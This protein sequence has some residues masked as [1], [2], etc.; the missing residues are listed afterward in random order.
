MQVQIRH[1]IPVTVCLLALILFIIPVTAGTTSVHIIKYA[2][3]GVTILD[4]QTVDF[5]WLETNLQVYGDGTTHY[6]HQGPVFNASITDKWNPEENDPAILTKD[7]GAVK[8]TDL[9]D[10]CDLVGGM[11]P[12]DNNVTLKASDGFSKVFAYSSVYTPE[13]RTGPIVLCW[14]RADLGYVNESF[15]TGIRNVM[16]ADTSVNPWGDHV[17]GL[18]DMHEAYPEE[19]WYYYQPGQPSTTGLSVQ[20]IDRVLIYSNEPAPVTLFDGMVTLTAGTTFSVVPYQNLT[21]DYMVDSTTPLGALNAASIAGSGFSYSVSDKSFAAKGILLL[22]EIG[23]Y[24]Y[25]KTTNMA[26]IC[27]VNGVT[28]DDYGSPSTDGFNIKELQDGDQVD[29]YFGVKPV[30]PESA[31]GV[32]KIL[33]DII[34]PGPVVDTLFNGTV[35]LTPGSTFSVVPYQNL[36]ADYTVDSTTPL[37]ALN[38]ASI[39]GSG[40]SYS[41]S[42][43]SYATKG[44]LLLDETGGYWYNK[45]TNMAWICQLNGVTLDDYGSPATDGFNIREVYDG[46]QVDYYFGLKPVTPEN[47]TAVA[48]ILVRTG[49]PPGDWNLAMN[50]RINRTISRQEFDDAL[51]CV[52]SG[53]NVTW[54]DEYGNVWGGIPLWVLVGMVDDAEG[55]AHWTFND[56]LAAEGYTV[57]VR[58]DDWD[59]SLASTDIAR[60]DGYIVANTLNGTPLP[61]NTTAGKPSWPL[62]LKGPL[63]FGGQQV[64]GIVAIDLI[65]LPEPSTG[66]DLTM[67]G[68]ITDVITQNEFEQGILCH[69]NVTYTDSG[70]NVWGGVPLWDMVGTVDDIESASHWTFN[71]TLA[72]AGYTV[73]VIA[74]DGFYVNFTSQNVSHNNGF[75]IANTLN[76][77]PITGT[78]AFLK[79]VGPATTSGQ[80]R[81]GNVTTIR[82][83]G[84]PSY[85]PGEYQLTLN[86]KISAVIP[87]PELEAW[88]ACHGADYTDPNGGVYH[89]MPLWRLCGWVDDRVPHSFD[90]AAAAAGYKIIV[91]AGDG[92]SKEF[93]GAS[94]ARSNNFIIANTLNGSA[95]PTEG[96]HPPWPLRLVG[97][98]AAGGNS[99]GNIVEIELTDFETPVNATPV[100]IIKYGSDGVT[101]INETT[102]SYTWMQQYLDVIGDGT[103]I[104]R[105]EAIT[106]NPDNVWDPEETYPGGYKISNAVKG[107]RL[108]DL[109]ELVG[110]MGS[111]T[112]IKLIAGDGYETTLPYSSIYTNPAVQ[113]RQ[114]DAILAWYADGT[115]V[116]SYPDGMR[117]F[118]T[119]GGD[120]VYGQWDMH[121]TLPDTYWHY[122]YD[123]GTQYPS[124]AGLSAKWITT[125]KIYSAPESDWN[126]SLDG[127]RIGGLSYIVSKNYFEQALACQFG[128]N[129]EARY[130]D[131]KGRIWDGMPLWFLCGFVDDG[132]Q[133]SDHAFNDTK[134]A[135]GYRVVVTASDGTNTTIDSRDMARNTGYIIASSLNGTHIPDTDSSWPLR[136]TGLDVESADSIKG[137]SRIDL[138]PPVTPPVP[139]SITV[140]LNTGWNIFSTPV[141]LQYDNAT[142]V[143]I[144]RE[145]QAISVILE[146][147]GSQWV[148][149]SGEDRLSPL[150]AIFVKT[151]GPVNATLVPSPDLTP[152]QSRSL[153]G[154]IS[155]VG[156]AP[157]WDSGLFPAMPISQAFASI[158]Y[159]P[160]GLTGYS[161][162]ISPAL[163]QPGWSYAKGMTMQ[164]L[165]PFK[166]YWVVMENPDTLWGF[167]TTPIGA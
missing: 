118:F 50:G 18:W 72:S 37:G 128:A 124:C 64:G 138:L 145:S 146:W 21:A 28:L 41:V 15:D 164:D 78:G 6:Y 126:L 151:T 105:Y 9:K 115:Y 40:F 142:L 8:G 117:V 69:H 44:I 148:I 75:I 101:V 92:Y 73:S 22:D 136:L 63:V 132:D 91:K 97:D 150:Y 1:F 96:S 140:P 135:E 108:K 103:T 24:W 58:S 139:G 98:G 155:L 61:L 31:S 62:H 33:V 160:G 52:P 67:E 10:L 107:T 88:I 45:T 104:Y 34:P 56:A 65:G 71:D 110:G 46:D 80:Q 17:F 60:N 53:H 133:H 30:T 144:F 4:E 121:E 39:A 154:G 11:S 94:V 77:T 90:D 112:D 36:T 85:P 129:H 95:L 158:E 127:T 57:K 20:N 123:Q 122:Y 81:V 114:G 70:G 23:G 55:G 113:A 27:Q 13:A 68:A 12:T 87:Q 161:M 102:V 120:H 116:P 2:N 153:P 152:P 156:P 7:M 79:L 89:G 84:L 47:A 14:Y 59:T 29:L 137:V 82:L 119:P 83:T 76:G 26:W 147:N 35:T 86:G 111:G 159:T 106:S 134:A 54:T 100:H 167:S 19:F 149:P 49:T 51:A 38:A 163:N 16:F 143:K 25:N 66:W 141:A 93:Q 130:T 32:V 5:Q 109:C 157:A 162:V 42:D 74:G 43:K 48:R 125:I 131:N 3:D 166:G 165:L 99:V